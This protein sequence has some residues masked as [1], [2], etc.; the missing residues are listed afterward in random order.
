MINRKQKKR[1]PCPYRDRTELKDQKKTNTGF[2]EADSMVVNW[3][4][5]RRKHA[6]PLEK[7]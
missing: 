4:L 3:Q 5:N 1:T 2:S 6:I 7:F